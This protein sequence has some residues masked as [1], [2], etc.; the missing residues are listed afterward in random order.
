M[1]AETLGVQAQDDT[2]GTPE[3]QHKTLRTSSKLLEP[4][5]AVF[6]ANKAKTVYAKQL[7]W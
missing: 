1:I 6:R 7:M 5:K 4:D 2:T 3:A